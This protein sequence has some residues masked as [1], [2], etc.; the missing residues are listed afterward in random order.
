M[1]QLGYETHNAIL[2]LGSLF[3]F[4]AIYI[5]LLII[6]VLVFRTLFKCCPKNLRIQKV[7]TWMCEFLYFSEFIALSLDCYLEL[8]V[9]G[10]LMIN[11]PLMTSNGEVLSI[12]VGIYAISVALLALPCITVYILFQNIDR[13]QEKDFANK[14]SKFYE[15]L[16]PNFKVA[17]FYPVIFMARRLIFTVLAFIM[18]DYPA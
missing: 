1:E 16:K 7:Y 17:L 8:T 9:S 6:N 13:L 12:Y 10:W 2:N 18:Y 15:D 11:A 4:I 14:W 3:I 5:V